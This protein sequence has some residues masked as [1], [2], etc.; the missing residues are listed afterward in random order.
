M[1][2]LYILLIVVSAVAALSLGAAA[3][4]DDCY[5]DWSVAAPIVREEGLVTVEQLSVAARANLKGDIVKTTLCR[6][7]GEY[8]FRLVVKSLNGQLRGLTVD[9]R[10][11]FER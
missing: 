4:D 1:V 7:R 2:R 6:E 5:G 3:A 9:A 10:R 11:P 8:V